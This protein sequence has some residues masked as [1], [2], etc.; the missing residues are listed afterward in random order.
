MREV[1]QVL[2]DEKD[3][4]Q[5]FMHE[6]EAVHGLLC[7]GIDDSEVQ[8]G[9]DIRAQEIG[10]VRKFKRVFGALRDMKDQFHAAAWTDPWSYRADI[11]VHRADPVSVGGILRLYI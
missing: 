2:A 6:L 1:L 3:V 8:G 9:M 11:R 10:G 5:F 4:H 7:F